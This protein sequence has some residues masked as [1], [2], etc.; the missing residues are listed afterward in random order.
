MVDEDVQ[1]D[2]HHQGTA[3][4]SEKVHIVMTGKFINEIKLENLYFK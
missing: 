3:V 4:E 2:F 1:N